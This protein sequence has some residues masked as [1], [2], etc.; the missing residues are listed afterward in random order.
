[1]PAANEGRM[2]AGAAN[3]LRWEERK[4]M[5]MIVDTVLARVKRRQRADGFYN[6]YPE[7]EAYETNSERKNY[8]R[9]VWTVGLLEAGKIG[10]SMLTR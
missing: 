3:A 4:D 1:L 6:Y 10:Y 2:L 9:L 5:R 8:D 7:K